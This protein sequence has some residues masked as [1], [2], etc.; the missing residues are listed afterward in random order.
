MKFRWFDVECCAKL[1]SQ[2]RLGVQVLWDQAEERNLPGGKYREARFLLEDAPADF[3]YR[4]YYHYD[5]MAVATR[6]LY[7]LLSQLGMKEHIQE[8]IRHCGKS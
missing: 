2:K 5:T 3:P 4:L 7:S 6:S 8:F 1:I